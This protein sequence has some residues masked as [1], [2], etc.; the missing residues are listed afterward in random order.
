MKKGFT[1]VEL[2]ITVS[3]IVLIGFIAVPGVRNLISDSKQKA[4][5]SMV[6]TIEDAAKSYTYLNSSDVDVTIAAN[7]YAD[8]TI[9]VLQQNGLLKTE[10]I[11]PLTNSSVSTS[12]VVRIT[13]NSNL[14]SFEYMGG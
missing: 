1:L 2:I 10:L 3:L 9:L 4:Y 6:N 14:Y 7:G 11:D 5:D 8:V 12:T 13:K